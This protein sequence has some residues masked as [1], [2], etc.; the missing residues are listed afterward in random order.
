M[1][2]GLRLH[3]AETNIHLGRQAIRNAQL[4]EPLNE[5]MIELHRRSVHEARLAR[6]TL[7]GQLQQAKS[8]QP[9]PSYSWI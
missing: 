2:L 7:R 8:S 5:V 6:N 1:E 9:L 4:E 3:E